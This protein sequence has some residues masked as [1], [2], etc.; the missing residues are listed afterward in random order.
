MN[1]GWHFFFFF[2]WKI[3]FQI[4]QICILSHFPRQF[5]NLASRSNIFI[6]KIFFELPFF[7]GTCW[8]IFNLFLN[9]IC[10]QFILLGHDEMMMNWTAVKRKWFVTHKVNFPSN[11]WNHVQKC[12]SFSH[13]SRSQTSDAY[14]VK[15]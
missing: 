7:T 1:L 4:W 12:Q 6:P 13:L 14:F 10:L 8:H 9:Y 3:K 5:G 15:K 2:F 11:L